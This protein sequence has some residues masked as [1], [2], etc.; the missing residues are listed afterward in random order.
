MA[1]PPSKLIFDFFGLESGVRV[2]YNV[3]Y[4]CVNFIFPGP[5]CSPLRPDVRDRRALSLNASYPKGGGIIGQN[6]N[7]VDLRRVKN[8][9]HIILV[10]KNNL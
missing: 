5:L 7:H 10:E 1:P 4:L 9:N 2:T 8:V 6:V 3:G